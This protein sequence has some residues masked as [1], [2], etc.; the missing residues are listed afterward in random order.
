MLENLRPSAKSAE[1]SVVE[2]DLLVQK[3]EKQNGEV[4]REWRE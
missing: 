1:K 4:A 2:L 3:H